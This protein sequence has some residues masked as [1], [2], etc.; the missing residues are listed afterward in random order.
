[1]LG[2]GDGDLEAGFRY[3]AP[4]QSDNVAAGIGM[5]ES[6]SHRFMAGAD[7]LL[8]PSR[9]EPCGLTQFY[10][11]RYGDAAA[12]PPGRRVGRHGGR[13]VNEENLAADEAT[14]LGSLRR[15][16]AMRALGARIRE[17]SA[18]PTATT[19]RPGRESSKGPCDFS[20]DDAANYE[21]LYRL[22]SVAAGWDM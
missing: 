18:V 3:A 17:A 15:W 5:I 1:M 19:G 2:S 16:R 11:L 4:G 7:A 12:G 14:G 6:M 13:C 8:V 21:Q 10:A 9:F 20:W 22:A